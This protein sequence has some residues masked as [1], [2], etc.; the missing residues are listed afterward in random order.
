MTKL[1]S[2]LRTK[3]TEIRHNTVQIQIDWAR[4]N[5]REK[6]ICTQYYVLSLLLFA[7]VCAYA[8]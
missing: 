8:P 4:E 1:P 5:W 3:I 2:M 6:K 7:K